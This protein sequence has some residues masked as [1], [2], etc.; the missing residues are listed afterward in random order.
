MALV[1]WTGNRVGLLG[2]RAKLNRREVEAQY[3]EFGDDGPKTLG[4]GW[5]SLEDSFK[6]KVKQP[7]IST[8]GKI[9]KRTILSDIVSLF[10]PMGLVAPVIMKAK[11][12]MHWLQMDKVAWDEPVPRYIYKEW[13]NFAENLP[14]LEELLIKR[15]LVYEKGARVQLHAFAYTSGKTYGAV[16]YARIT[17]KERIQIML[18]GAKTRIAPTRKELSIERLGLCSAVMAAELLQS[19]S[20]SLQIPTFIKNFVWLGS[21]AALAWI[22]KRPSKWEDFVAE[23]VAKIHKLKH[24][25][26]NFVEYEENP[27]RIATGGLCPSKLKSNKLWWCGP[28]WLPR[29]ESWWPNA[30]DEQLKMFEEA[31]AQQFRGTSDSTTA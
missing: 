17:H 2:Q 4:F 27:A 19:I 29:H 14:A 3:V 28:H 13:S 7:T 25:E 31:R 11:L 24:T 10:D 20:D 23:R 6:Y 8:V 16:V 9:T 30:V 21:H 18:L 1:D 22:A 15:H 5:S 12:I 26:W